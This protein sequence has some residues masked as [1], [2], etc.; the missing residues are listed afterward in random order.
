MSDVYI[1][2]TRKAITDAQEAVG[3]LDGILDKSF[4]EVLNTLIT[5]S[6]SLCDHAESQFEKLESA[7]EALK[8]NGIEV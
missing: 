1:R 8:E 2:D 4:I 6:D 3:D 7:E 5:E